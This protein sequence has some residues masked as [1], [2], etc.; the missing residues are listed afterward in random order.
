[1]IF[2]GIED[3]VNYK[4]GQDDKNNIGVLSGKKQGMGQVDCWI[5]KIFGYQ[6]Q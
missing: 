6:G 5:V 2:Q 1:M 4:M 3:Q